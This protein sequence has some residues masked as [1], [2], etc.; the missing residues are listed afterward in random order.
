M[1]PVVGYNFKT[2]MASNKLE[3]ERDVLAEEYE[4]SRCTGCTDDGVRMMGTR[5][6]VQR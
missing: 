2:E 5:Q 6:C 1:I 3:H 4:F